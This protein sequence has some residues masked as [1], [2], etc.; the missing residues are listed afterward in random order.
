MSDLGTKERAE[1]KNR[2]SKARS[3]LLMLMVMIIYSVSLEGQ[4]QD[5]NVSENL[6]CKM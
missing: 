6:F 1:W 4:R 2:I 5:L 3:L